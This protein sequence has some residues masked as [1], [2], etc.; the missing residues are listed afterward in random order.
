M[1]NNFRKN[2]RKAFT[3]VELVI[4]IAVIA[5]LAAV[6][7]PTFSNIIKKADTSADYQN[8]RAMNIS[9][10]NW[11]VLNK[12]KP[13]DYKEVMEALNQG[14]YC[15]ASN[16][17][18]VACEIRTPGAYLFWDQETNSVTLLEDGI[19]PQFFAANG[20]APNFYNNQTGVGEGNVQNNYGY[21]LSTAYTGD[22]GDFAE[23]YVGKLGAAQIQDSVFA[24]VIA[25]YEANYAAGLTTATAITSWY[26]TD[27][28]ESGTFTKTITPTYTQANGTT[29]ALSTSLFDTKESL[30]E[31]ISVANAQVKI[32]AT[33]YL[34]GVVTLVNSG[35]SLA[36]IEVN[37]APVEAYV[38][39]NGQVAYRAGT[40]D[41]TNTT[42][43]PIADQPRKTANTDSIFMGQLNMG[44]TDANGVTTST[45]IKGL[46]PTN[47]YVNQSAELQTYGDAG[48]SAV[49]SST[50]GYVYMFNYGL[51]AFVASSY[52]KDATTGVYRSVPAIVENISFE[53]CDLDLTQFTVEKNGVAYPCFTDCGSLLCGYAVGDVIIRNVVVGSESNPVKLKAYDSVGLLIGRHYDYSNL[54]NGI[55]LTANNMV[56]YGNGSVNCAG[57]TTVIYNCKVYGTV[58]GDRRCGGLV[59]YDR[60]KIVIL[61]T[62]TAKIDS[63]QKMNKTKGGNY[64]LSI[65]GYLNN[66]ATITI[67]NCTIDGTTTADTLYDGSGNAVN[68]TAKLTTNQFAYKDVNHI[69][70]ETKADSKI[71]VSNSTI[72]G[73]AISVNE[74]SPATLATELQ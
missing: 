62:V 70:L 23:W 35:V 28:I 36:G 52:E 44:Y 41:L 67:K 26:T 56:T 33:K 31:A 53:D 40:I 27:V 66:T 10:Y 73:K 22:K 61:D 58:E 21:I 29:V 51:F 5:I 60:A 7:I 8:V 30:E 49:A 57:A 37:V 42:W 74:V 72:F 12:H 50:D 65:V 14:G 38:D 68:A 59:G 11:E 32:E 46:K 34:A 16:M 17:Y 64:E 19:A 18:L 71:T 20:D 2:G 55:S 39:S 6:L 4:V 15:D 43:T 47:T 24:A 3:I 54:K 9:L 1:N 48:I 13:T 45:V 69:L 25:Q 63:T